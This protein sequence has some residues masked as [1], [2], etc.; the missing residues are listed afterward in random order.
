MKST[1]KVGTQ[2]K[3]FVLADV[4]YQVFYIPYS[5]DVPNKSSWWAALTNKPRVC[6]HVHNEGENMTIVFQE[7]G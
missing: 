7:S 2:Y 1:T 5:S 6:L 3:P 4:V